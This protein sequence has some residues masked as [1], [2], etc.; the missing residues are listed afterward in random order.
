M[1]VGRGWVE[2]HV[3]EEQVMSPTGGCTGLIKDTGLRAGGWYSKIEMTATL[4]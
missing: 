1:G 2:Q 4:Y 3:G